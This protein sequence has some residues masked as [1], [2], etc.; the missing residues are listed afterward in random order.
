[1]NKS[2][3]KCDDKTSAAGLCGVIL[4]SLL[5]LMNFQEV[6]T[7]IPFRA[8]R[9]IVKLQ[10]S[11]SYSIHTCNNR[12]VGNCVDFFCAMATNS[13]VNDDSRESWMQQSGN[14]YK[15]DDGD[16]P[17]PRRSRLAD[18]IRQLDMAKRIETVEYR[19]SP[20]DTVESSSTPEDNFN[21][22]VKQG[23]F[24]IKSAEQHTY[25][26]CLL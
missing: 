9:P 4:L 7:M 1:M 11:R 25:V 26:R 23:I 12:I 5:L 18:R 2:L 21:F 10:C 16:S 6:E 24:Q 15:T 19:T 3:V 14:T 13:D 22:Q 20:A 8:N 17:A